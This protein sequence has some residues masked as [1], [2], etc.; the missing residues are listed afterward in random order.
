MEQPRFGGVPPPPLSQLSGEG[1]SQGSIIE[2][3]ESESMDKKD[4]PL[5]RDD[6]YSKVGQEEWSL[7]AR[8]PD[9][10]NVMDVLQQLG[11]SAHLERHRLKHERQK[12]ASSADTDR[13]VYCKNLLLKDKKGQ[14]YLI[15]CDENDTADLRVV[16][17]H[18]NAHGNLHF[19]SKESLWNLLHV[20]PGALTPLAFIHPSSREVR[21]F[22]DASLVKRINRGV[23]KLF[24]H[25]LRPELQVGLTL[26]QLEKFLRHCG[27][28]MET[29]PSLISYSAG[30]R[31]CTMRIGSRFRQT[32][33]GTD[34]NDDEDPEKSA[35]RK[36]EEDLKEE[37]L[38][39]SL[40][41]TA[42]PGE[43]M[44][45]TEMLLTPRKGLFQELGINVEV[46]PAPRG[47]GAFDGSPLSCKCVYLKD[48]RGAYFLFI[49][50]QNQKVDFSHLKMQLKPKKKITPLEREELWSLLQ[51]R[52]DQQHP[53]S[54]AQLKQPRFLVAVADNLYQKD[55]AVLTFEH[56]SDCSL[57]QKV[58]LKD[59]E[60]FVRGV[61]H[62]MIRIPV[63][64]TLES[65]EASPVSTVGSRLSS[66]STASATACVQHPETD[67]TQG[68]HT[69]S[70]AEHLPPFDHN[71]V[72]AVSSAKHG[73]NLFYHMT[74][75]LRDWISRCGRL[76]IQLLE[77]YLPNWIFASLH[78]LSNRMLMLG[79]DVET[80]MDSQCD[81]QFILKEDVTRTETVG[82]KERLAKISKLKQLVDKSEIPVKMTETSQV[83]GVL[84]DNAERCKTHLL[85]DGLGCLYLI[86]CTENDDPTQQNFRRLRTALRSRSTLNFTTGEDIL[87][88]LSWKE[89]ET[90][91][92]WAQE[93]LNPLVMLD[94][95]LQT[96]RRV[97]VGMTRA[98]YSFPGTTVSFDLPPLGVTLWMSCDDME[99]IMKR[100]GLCVVYLP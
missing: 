26:A 61:G 50:H 51:L 5:F 35:E 72:L 81:S 43:L 66:S 40:E 90:T 47:L 76:I 16:K 9:V 52:E 24:F 17:Y 74:A 38:Q 37:G 92:S 65:L 15:V 57:R 83:A 30:R 98:M 6:G 2:T 55:G 56:P 12:D 80:P 91:M 64:G 97:R 29:L 82:G 84:K 60:T 14:A 27:V 13:E 77:R 85:Q 100:L 70:G 21:V 4:P 23:T 1:K 44:E 95:D 39:A 68:T 45:H 58:T 41:H 19:A 3:M 11:I 78:Q 34:D 79:Q 49:C 94:L 36:M 59:L 63:K 89:G 10:Q 46:V 8:D 71:E 67:S 25:P 18:L 54:L 75:P 96:L 22:V 32:Y 28:T 7:A 20:Q 33:I 53:F 62:D 69:G 48:K 87:H 42:N 93:E 99:R 31:Y 73:E 88:F 86:L